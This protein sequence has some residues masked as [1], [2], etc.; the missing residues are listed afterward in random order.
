M[1]IFTFCY[2]GIHEEG[3][4]KELSHYRMKMLKLRKVIMKWCMKD[5]C[6]VYHNKIIQEEDR[7]CADSQFERGAV[8]SGPGVAN[9]RSALDAD[10]YRNTS[11]QWS[12]VNDLMSVLRCLM[13]ISYPSSGDMESFLG[14]YSDQDHCNRVEF[15][16]KFGVDVDEELVSSIF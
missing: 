9:Y 3:S 2:A 5:L 4:S 8:V 10:S 7:K 1:K 15:A 14:K 6:S 13:F 12:S 16:C 11:D